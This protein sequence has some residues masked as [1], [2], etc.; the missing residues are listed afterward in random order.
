MNLMQD[1]RDR[2]NSLCSHFIFVYKNKNCGI[3]PLSAKH[4]NVWCGDK[5][6]ILDSI[7]SVMTLDFFDGK[8]LTDIVRDIEIIDW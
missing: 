3:D 4:F 7:D 5:T 2:I 6:T 1:V 8:S